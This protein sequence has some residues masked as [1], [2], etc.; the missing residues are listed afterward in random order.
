[1]TLPGKFPPGRP[2]H[3]RGPEHPHSTAHGHEG[4]SAAPRRISDRPAARALDGIA[5]FGK[6]LY[7]RLFHMDSETRTAPHAEK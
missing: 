1:M 3:R 7:A 2:P 4:R 5:A 6:A